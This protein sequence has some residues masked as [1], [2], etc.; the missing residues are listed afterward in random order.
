MRALILAIGVFGGA[1]ISSSAFAQTEAPL[2]CHDLVMPITGVADDATFSFTIPVDDLAA[3]CTSATEA[4]VTV[5]TPVDDVTVT[6]TPNSSQ[7]IIFTVHDSDGNTATGHV[8][9]TRD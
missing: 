1:V 7:T 4:V 6:P 3:Q 5:V 9:V 8:I 2:I